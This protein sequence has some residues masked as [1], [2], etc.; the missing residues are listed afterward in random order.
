ML[1]NPTG[2]IYSPLDQT[3]EGTEPPLV[4]FGLKRSDEEC[5]VVGSVLPSIWEGI[6]ESL[7]PL[8]KTSLHEYPR[9]GEE[10]LA[11]QETSNHEKS[12]PKKSI[13]SSSNQSETEKVDNGLENLGCLPGTDIPRYLHLEPSLAMDWLE[14]SW[15]DLR[16]KERVGAGTFSPYFL[17]GS[18][19]LI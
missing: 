14:I 6:S 17:T 7:H 8:V 11:V 9:L 1:I 3:S 19:L 15:D 4:T 2:P 5:A 13:S 16:I 10:P 12:S 18:T